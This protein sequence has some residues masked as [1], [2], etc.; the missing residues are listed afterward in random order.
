M[1]IFRL[2]K[3]HQANYSIEGSIKESKAL[4]P[5]RKGWAYPAG[6]VGMPR[7]RMVLHF[8]RRPEVLLRPVLQ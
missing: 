5:L 1:L 2:E 7:Q 3:E 4:E 8:P 6:C